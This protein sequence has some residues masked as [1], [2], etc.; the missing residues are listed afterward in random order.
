MIPQGSVGP[1]RE[2][3]MV[4]PKKGLRRQ[5]RRNVGVEPISSTYGAQKKGVAP[6]RKARRQERNQ[7]SSAASEES[8]QS[9]V[10]ISSDREELRTVENKGVLLS[11]DSSGNLRYLCAS[12]AG[13]ADAWPQMAFCIHAI[14]LL[15]VMAIQNTNMQRVSPAKWGVSMGL[16]PPTGEQ[17]NRTMR[18]ARDQGLPVPFGAQQIPG[19]EPITSMDQLLHTIVAISRQQVVEQEPVPGVVPGRTN[20]P[21]VLEA[22]I[23]GD[24]WTRYLV[25]MRQHTVYVLLDGQQWGALRPVTASQVPVWDLSESWFTPPVLQQ[26]V[27]YEHRPSVPRDQWGVVKTARAALQYLDQV[28]LSWAY[29]SGLADLPDV[30]PEGRPQRYQ[31]ACRNTLRL[32]LER[33]R[34]SEQVAGTSERAQLPPPG[35]PVPQTATAPEPGEMDYLYSYKLSS[36]DADLEDRRWQECDETL[37]VNT[38]LPRKGTVGIAHAA[39]CSALA[40]IVSKEPVSRSQAA[41]LE[42]RLCEVCKGK[43]TT[44]LD[45]NIPRAKLQT[46]A[47]AQALGGALTTG[48]P[49]LNADITSQILKELSSLRQELSRVRQDPGGPDPTEGKSA[50]SETERQ[51]LPQCVYILV[52]HEDKGIALVRPVENLRAEQQRSDS[53]QFLHFDR[54]TTDDS[55]TVGNRPAANQ[56]VY[57]FDRQVGQ[58]PAYQFLRYVGSEIIHRTY[59]GGKPQPWER[60]VFEVRI[61]AGT[62]PTT[63]I[64]E[65]DVQ[66]HP[67]QQVSTIFGDEPPRDPRFLEMWRQRCTS[68]LDGHVINWLLG[69]P[70]YP[71]PRDAHAEP[72]FRLHRELCL[73]IRAEPA[74]GED[75]MVLLVRLR[76]E[77]LWDFPKGD[78]GDGDP[79]A[80][81]ASLW[82]LQVGYWDVPPMTLGECMEL[83]DIR[84]GKQECQLVHGCVPT[85]TYCIHPAGTQE[86]VWMSAKQLYLGI[87]QPGLSK[88]Q[89]G[90]LQLGGDYSGRHTAAVRAWLKTIPGYANPWVPTSA[91]PPVPNQVPCGANLGPDSS[92]QEVPPNL[93]QPVGPIDQEPHLLGPLKRMHVIHLLI[94]HKDG[95]YFAITLRD[96]E[97]QERNWNVPSV[98]LPS[99]ES[100]EEKDVLR[101]RTYL[102]NTAGI[103]LVPAEVRWLATRQTLSTDTSTHSCIYVG[104]LASS[105]TGIRLGNG[106]AKGWSWHPF[107]TM[108][109]VARF[110]DHYCLTPQTLADLPPTRTLD[111]DLGRGMRGATNLDSAASL[112]QELTQ[113][114][115]LRDTIKAGAV[116]LLNKVPRYT[117]QPCVVSTASGKAGPRDLDATLISNVH[118]LITFLTQVQ[119]TMERSELTAC[120]ETRC[121]D[122]APICPLSD[123]LMHVGKDRV[124]TDSTLGR[125]LLPEYNKIPRD[126]GACMSMEAFLKF[127][128]SKMVRD[129]PLRVYADQLSIVQA[130]CVTAQSMTVAQL[131]EMVTAIRTFSQLVRTSDCFHHLAS[132]TADGTVVPVVREISEAE[133]A[134]AFLNGLNRQATPPALSLYDQVSEFVESP[135]NRGTHGTL[136]EGA[137]DRIYEKALEYEPG[138]L[139]QRD[140]DRT[141]QARG[142]YNEMIENEDDTLAAVAGGERGRR[143]P[144]IDPALRSREGGRGEQP[145]RPRKQ[146]VGAD[147]KRR[148]WSCGEEGHLARDCPSNP[149]Q[150]RLHAV[151]SA[152]LQEQGYPRGLPTEDRLYLLDHSLAPEKDSES[153]SE[154]DSS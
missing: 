19:A 16:L 54:Q 123:L 26:I 84:G 74:P 92:E 78:H 96:F 116:R 87:N 86:C 103:S 93:D 73:L 13:L 53:R 40:R 31:E 129:R 66:Y 111:A 153:G 112:R 149:T 5:A 145:P 55:R 144:R 82:R 76:G 124:T 4:E 110:I 128:V 33:L 99:Q 27:T 28:T 25:D 147:G 136:V 63:E 102:E 77:N 29:G 133:A 60:E 83:R 32:T 36:P 50:E 61:P 42:Y 20:P 37:Y 1:K 48:D 95:L 97:E 52:Y 98:S 67:L 122:G 39:S 148:C 43:S 107:L 17:P 132:T 56:A 115:K 6:G 130:G 141:A 45:Q 11:S 2:G 140:R 57:W 118:A 91:P 70:Q 44:V 71:G 51:Q 23:R 131:Y 21:S 137:L 146:I 117:G 142:R 121:A 41:D 89:P 35:L 114:S 127:T 62:Q 139:A 100:S 38:A 24:D 134:G 3:Q 10:S 46:D 49:T 85:N 101:C 120:W 30:T 68:E 72:K 154:N 152:D 88:S 106:R 143:E 81:A 104:Q 14:R 59:P 7:S 15:P 69:L 119:L 94:K 108:K 126:A 109:W 135:N 22:L 64:G 65:G 58:Y 75:H 79:L 105:W 80:L 151:T 125:E 9:D 150:Q 138:S 90:R 18:V 34:V 8:S 47:S 113:D 12:A